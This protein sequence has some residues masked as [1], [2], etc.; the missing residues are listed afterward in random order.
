MTRQ[1]FLMK[2]NVP[3]YE[4]KI[5]MCI[6]SNVRK[7]DWPPNSLRLPIR[8]PPEEHAWRHSWFFPHHWVEMELNSVFASCKQN[9]IKDM[10][11]SSV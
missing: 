11:V 3:E 8:G 2:K 5:V 10:I 4:D 7:E 1:F 6:D 9:P